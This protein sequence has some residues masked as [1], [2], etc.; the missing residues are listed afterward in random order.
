MLLP[1][2][3]FDIPGQALIETLAWRAC[4][5]GPTPTPEASK[6]SAPFMGEVIVGAAGSNDS[7]YANHSLR[8]WWG[9]SPKRNAPTKIP[10][11]MR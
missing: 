7:D 5:M 3:G 4:W 11:K 9:S 1:E 8:D 6:T 2:Y 10:T